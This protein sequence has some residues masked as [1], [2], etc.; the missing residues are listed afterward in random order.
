MHEHE[1]APFFSLQMA[2]APHGDG[3]QGVGIST[4][5][6]TGEGMQSINALKLFK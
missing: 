6:N 1:P 2:L 5:S 4:G 3:S